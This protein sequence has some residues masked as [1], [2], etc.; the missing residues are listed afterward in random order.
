MSQWNKTTR[1]AHHSAHFAATPSTPDLRPI[2]APERPISAHYRPAKNGGSIKYHQMAFKGGKFF[3]GMQR[4]CI[5]LKASATARSKRFLS[6]IFG[7]SVRLALLTF[8]EL[9][10]E[11]LVTTSGRIS[12][13]MDQF[14]SHSCNNVQ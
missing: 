14:V 13:T 9:I 3:Q 4:D 12:E 1:P 5:F 11:F 8:G 6:E 2:Y 7:E 10:W